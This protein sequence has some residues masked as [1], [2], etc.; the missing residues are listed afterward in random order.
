MNIKNEIL[1]KEIMTQKERNSFLVCVYHS[2]IVIVRNNM[3]EFN[4]VKIKF[5]I[6]MMMILMLRFQ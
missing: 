4:S 5:L 1:L 3:Y 2:F 6:M